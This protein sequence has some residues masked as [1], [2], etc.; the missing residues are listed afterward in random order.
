MIDPRKALAGP[1]EIQLFRLV[2]GIGLRLRTL[3][4]QRL[5]EIGLTTQQAALLTLASAASP[6]A[7]LQELAD[8]LGCT[9]QNARQLV[10]ALAR[11]GLVEV[12]ADP[13]DRR[14]R[15]IRCTSS[16][17]ALFVDRDAADAA[18]IRAWFGALSDDEL[19]TA[20]ELLGRVPS[21]LP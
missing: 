5:A 10:D 21:R 18:A 15:R 11:K 8:A 1:P 3:M 4:D 16:V 6:A 12:V 17:E 20:A 13:A 9:H 2:V 7:T 19:A 14:V